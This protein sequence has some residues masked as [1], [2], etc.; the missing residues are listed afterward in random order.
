MANSRAR[1]FGGPNSDAD[2]DGDS[3]GADFLAWQQQFGSGVSSSATLQAVPEPSTVV[4]FGGFA[5]VGMLG[6][7]SRRAVSPHVSRTESSP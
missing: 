4:L 1:D 2:R 6:R 3:D 5:A 7:R